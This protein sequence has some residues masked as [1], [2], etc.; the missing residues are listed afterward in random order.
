MIQKEHSTINQLIPI[1]H[2][3]KDYISQLG[4][5][6]VLRERLC[7]MDL[8]INKLQMMPSTHVL[9]DCLVRLEDRLNDQHK[10]IAILHG[11]VWC[12]SQQG[13]LLMNLH[14]VRGL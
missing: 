1:V 4:Q 12:C 6:K 2:E 9:E 10:E 11:Q 7:L 5:I 13:N 8:Q 3:L 14:L